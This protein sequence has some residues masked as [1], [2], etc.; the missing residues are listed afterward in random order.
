MEASSQREPY[1]RWLIPAALF[2][3]FF[4]IAR[5]YPDWKAQRQKNADR[6][7]DDTKQGDT[8]PTTEATTPGSDS[9][10]SS[11]WPKNFSIRWIPYIPFAVVYLVLKA[12]WT[13]LRLLIL[14]SILFA[15]HA[16]VHLMVAVEKAAQWS[17][18]KGPDFVRDNIVVPICSI[19]VALWESPAMA[20][21]KTTIEETIIPGI[22]RISISTHTSLKAVFAKVVAWIHTVADPVKLAAV[23]FAVECLYNPVHAIGSR[24]ATL[25]HT[26]LQTAKI[27]I[28]ELAKDAVDLGKVVGRI[29]VWIWTW[30]LT[31]LWTKL[32]ALGNTV[33]NGLR[34]FLPWLGRNL[35]TRLFAP[36]GRAAVEGF[37]ILRSHPTLLAGL[38]ALSSKAQEKCSL[39]LQ[40]LESV[41]WLILLETVLTKAFTTAHHYTVLVLTVIGSGL[42]YFAVEMVPN[43]YQDLMNALE[44]ARPVVA[45]VIE[46]FMQVAHPLWQ[47]VSWVSWAVYTHTG[48]ALAWLH[49]KIV[50]PAHTLWVSSVLP[51]LTTVTNAVI[52]NATRI[53]NMILKAAP[54][55]AAV[56]VPI[57]NA[58]AHVALAL[59]AVTAQAGARVVELAGGLGVH[60]QRLAPQFE[61]FKVQTGRVM[62]ELVL[63]ISNFMMDWVKKEKRD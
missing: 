43:A 55:L 24:L 47:V 58:M 33:V 29:G 7:T 53:S 50:L 46:K 17:V 31:P 56:V 57:W 27:Y 60:I 26:F 35:Y 41:N 3:L 6:G 12:L 63:S 4:S 44:L 54:V 48:P 2:L 39:A 51:V 5:E 16:G 38:Q 20:K 34:Q 10:V 13:S 30:T 21:A 40:R 8:T 52:A 28:G 14:H 32:C 45:W 23:W 61:A 25:S 42:R 11:P 19:A 1:Y 22:V 49:K 15:E 18:Q 59:Q 37:R 36:V 62:D 9:T